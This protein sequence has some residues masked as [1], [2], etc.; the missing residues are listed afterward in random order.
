MLSFPNPSRDFD[1]TRN[2]VSF[3][4]YDQLFVVSFFV[5]ANALSTF[6]DGEL[7]ERAYLNAFDDQLELIHK[8]AREIYSRNKGTCY[9]IEELN[10]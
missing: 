5:E 8:I 7:S 2:A 10:I 4:G 9:I 6:I 3:V 1:T